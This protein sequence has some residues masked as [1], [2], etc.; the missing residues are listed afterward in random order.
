MSASHE[1]IA[2]TVCAGISVSGVHELV[3]HTLKLYR[4]EG[5]LHGITKTWIPWLAAGAAI[6][7]IYA[8]AEEHPSPGS[9]ISRHIDLLPTQPAKGT[10]VLEMMLGMVRKPPELAGTS[11][12]A[13]TVQQARRE[14][15]A[16]MAALVRRADCMVAAR[17]DT[18]DAPALLA[19]SDRPA[20][21]G[22][23]ILQRQFCQFVSREY[24]LPLRE[25]PEFVHE[26]RVATRRMRAVL[27]VFR[28][29]LGPWADMAKDRLSVI[30]GELG[31][32]RDADVFGL[33]LK[34]YAQRCTEQD[35]PFIDILMNHEKTLARQTTR[36]LIRHVRFAGHRRFVSRFRR[37]MA[38]H[39]A[40]E[41]GG[42]DRTP[43]TLAALAPGL[44]KHQL[45][46]V[47]KY[48]CP[49]MDYTSDELHS[50]RIACKRL[51][52]TAEFL[53]ELYPDGLRDL[54]DLGSSMQS[55]LGGV[56][57]ADVYRKRVETCIQKNPALQDHISHEAALALYN[58]L[59]AR[60]SKQLRKAVNI[61]KKA[62]TKRHRKRLR[63]ATGGG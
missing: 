4:K 28:S 18:D 3:V 56:H 54:V 21:A 33:F 24:G 16:R 10:L 41:P 55:L 53:S 42:Q 8:G 17:A 36:Q 11:V 13:G 23:K 62:Q 26:M 2:R 25:D 15:A 30:A 9:C 44:L 58:H 19:A 27:H 31:K 45:K 52:Y 34:S 63:N 14:L 35:L 57:D 47:L 12:R 49:L 29:G 43:E 22:I 38:N 59:D 6:H 39:L 7:G 46:R 37:Q 32:T 1:D 48:D 5:H 51:R 61:W 40:E 50:L 60:R 20:E